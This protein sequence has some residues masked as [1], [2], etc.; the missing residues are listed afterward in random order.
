MTDLKKLTSE[1]EAIAREA[2]SFISKEALSF[3]IGRAE[4]KGLNN[5]VSYVDKGAEKIIVNKLTALLPEAGF[6]A[7]EGTSDKRGKI[8][9]WVVDP[10]D[11][12]TNFMH[13]L[14]PYAVSIALREHD[15]PVAGAVFEITRNEMFTGWKNGGAWL[16]GKIIHVSDAVKMSESLIATGFPYT[17]FS[18]FDGYM[19][20]FSWC[21]QHTHG[22]R[23]LGSAATDIAYVACGRFEGFYEYGLY[24]WDI[25]AAT[26]ILREAGGRISDF[27]GNE[28]ALTGSEIIAASEAVFLEMLKI[29]SN[30]MKK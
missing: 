28:K 7:E 16:D 14:P 13:G 29:V 8:Y 1:I 25:A 18:R 24:P 22:V 4:V 11:G 10:L 23:R 15:E 2:G 19:E 27:S 30:F 3:D 20:L 21:C 6:E 17:D 5:F 26:I 12:T 9:N